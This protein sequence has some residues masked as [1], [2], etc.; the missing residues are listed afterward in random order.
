[1]SRRA[2]TRL[3]TL[4]FTGTLLLVASLDAQAQGQLSFEGPGGRGA[5]PMLESS[6]EILVEGPMLEGRVVQTFTNPLA[7]PIEALYV[8][9]L[10]EGAAVHHMELRAGS[11]RIVAVARKRAE[12]RREYERAKTEGRKAALVEKERANLF[13]MAAAH[14]APGE[15][16]EVELAF[17]Q[18]LAAREGHWELALPLT[19]TPQHTPAAAEALPL[20]VPFQPASSPAVPRVKLVARLDSGAPI[21]TLVSSSHEIDTREEGRYAVVEPRERLLLADRDFVLRWET[22]AG[23]AATG[24]FHVEDAQDG[25]YAMA[26]LHA[27]EVGAASLGQPTETVFVIDVSGSMDGP[28]IAAART[29]LD[30]ALARLRP[31]DA[32]EVIAF[33]DEATP[34]FGSLQPA[35]ASVVEDARSRARSLRADG[36]TEILG[37]LRQALAVLDAAPESASRARSLVFLTDGA[38]GNEGEILA[39]LRDSLHGTRLHAIGIGNAPNRHLMRK[40]ASFGRGLCSFIAEGPAVARELDAFLERVERPLLHDVSLRFE[41]AQPLEMIPARLPDL[42]AGDPL[43]VSLRFAPGTR[44]DAVVLEGVAVTGPAT[45][46][47]RIAEVERADSSIALRWGRAR[48]EEL[49][50]SLHEGVPEDEVREEVV[51]LGT[52]FNLA[53]RYTSLVAVE[54]IP[55][56]EGDPRSLHVPSGLPQGMSALPRGG[57]LRPLLLWGGSGLLIIGLALLTLPALL[58]LAEVRR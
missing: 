19:F 20:G 21:E 37:A 4:L 39:A 1:M 33:S 14:V 18:E 49:L 58:G 7:E 6:I 57:T 40:M 23:P 16:V 17:V 13:R 26:V 51:A 44:P 47:L 53:T 34:F 8:F 5:L 52:R 15:R 22:L 36:G 30:A 56:S 32:F 9:P 42:L 10:P 27:P 38:V 55:S 35:R 28:S 2:R 45:R 29:S 50:D 12:A 3:V 11:R 43:V 24:S 41:G 25:T 48:I 46:T 31:G 54:T